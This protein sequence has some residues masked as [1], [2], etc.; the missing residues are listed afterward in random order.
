MFLSLL[1]VQWPRRVVANWE[2]SFQFLHSHWVQ[3]CKPPWTP[4]PGDRGVF[5]VECTTF[6]F[7]KAQWECR[8]W[9]YLLILAG[10][11]ESSVTSCAHQPQEGRG[12]AKKKWHKPEPLP[13]LLQQTLWIFFMD[14]LVT[15]QIAPFALGP[16]AT[17]SAH[18]PLRAVFQFTSTLWVSWICFQGHINLEVH[19]SGAGPQGQGV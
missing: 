1:S 19:L 6:S 7:S 13:L 3:V 2:L 14:S 16:R 15:F 4:E 5:P 12:R 11:W 8:A 10:H 9:V 18:S 17:K